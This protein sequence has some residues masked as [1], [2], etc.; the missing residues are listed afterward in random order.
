MEEV[1]FSEDELH[2]LQDG[3]SIFVYMQEIY[4]GQQEE[5]PFSVYFFVFMIDSYFLNSLSTDTLDEWKFFLERIESEKSEGL[6][7]DNTKE[8]RKW[9]S[10]RGQTLSRTGD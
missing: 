2:S 3:A 4:P 6:F 8:M 1:T 10:F 7:V 5:S 9:A